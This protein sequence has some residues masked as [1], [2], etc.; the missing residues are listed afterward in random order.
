[1]KVRVNIF[2][3]R[4]E[5]VGAEY[6]D[7]TQEQLEDV[8]SH[9]RQLAGFVVRGDDDGVHAAA[10]ELNEALSVVDNHPS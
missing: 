5:V 10:A 6:L 7:F 4:G 3:N 8:I 9:A 2:D 1:M